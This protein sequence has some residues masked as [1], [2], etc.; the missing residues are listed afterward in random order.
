M[1]H[2]FHG[3]QPGPAARLNAVLLVSVLSGEPTNN[4]YR[5][6]NPKC[7]RHNPHPFRLSF[8]T[9]ALHLISFRL[10]LYRPMAVHA[11]T[12]NAPTIHALPI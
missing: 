8:M 11:A 5:H 9:P 12:Q 7:R 6:G 2:L 1:G 4:G 10:K 3:R